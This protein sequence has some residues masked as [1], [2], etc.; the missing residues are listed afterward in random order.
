MKDHR[1]F[2]TL[3]GTAA[4]LCASLQPA[5]AGN[6]TYDDWGSWGQVV[7]EGSLGLID[8]NLQ[9]GRLWLEGQ[10]RWDGDW[11][12]WYQG[13]ARVALGYSLSDRFTVWMGYTFLPT[14]N[15]GKPY[16]GQQDMWP[17]LRYVLPT[18]F[19]TFTY[20]FMWETNFIAAGSIRERPRQMLRFMHPIEAEPRLSLIVWDEFFV[21]A[22]TTSAG[23]QA[24]FDQNRIFGGFGWTFNPNFRTELGYMNQYIENANHTAATMHNLIMGS[25]FISF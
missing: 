7:A 15:I 12:H 11:Q 14:Q 6:V 5:V 10:S 9:K 22:T 13:V 19:G 17:A 3:A 25:L 1:N 20:R 16:V 8:P 18:E 23:G 2:K 21:R 4:I 24:G